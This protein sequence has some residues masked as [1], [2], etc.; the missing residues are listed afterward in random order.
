MMNCKFVLSNRPNGVPEHSDFKMIESEIP[1]I[2]SGEVLLETMFL[3]VDPYMRGRMREGGDTETWKLGEVMKA[4][5]VGEIIESG[6]EEFSPG[7]IVTD[8]YGR[9]LEWAKY[10]RVDGDKLTQVT[11]E[12]T[13]KSAAL[14][15]VGQTGRTAYFG[16]LDVGRPK[17][18][19][20]VVVSAAAG[21][22]GSVVGQIAK[23]AG[24]TVVGIT[25]SKKKRKYLTNELGFDSAINYK[26]DEISS[27]IEEICPYG[28]DIYFD[29]VGGEIRDAVIDY[30][31][32]RARVVVCGKIALYNDEESELRGKRYMHQRKRVREEGFV[33]GD[34]EHRFEEA[35]QRL[36]RWVNSGDISFRQTVVEDFKNSPGAL[37]GLFKG[38]NIGKQI[39]SV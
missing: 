7:D 17:P 10:I 18:G 24:C 39:V 37:I 1:D 27:R 11:P 12:L 32:I 13:P 38:D 14:G 26:K 9:G 8:E 4:R 20:T 3:S 31:S 5:V 23:L 35:D 25:G 22:V 19:D 21:A 28:V 2:N 33:I 36:M 6:H 30:L 15:V 16:L 29:S 34:Y